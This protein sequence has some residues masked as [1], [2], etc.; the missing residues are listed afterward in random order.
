MAML[1]WTLIWGGVYSI[2][3]TPIL[4]SLFILE[5]WLEEKLTLTKRFGEAY[6]AYRKKIPAFF[7]IVLIVPLLITA[8][9]IG[10]GILAGWISLV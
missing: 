3:L 7:P 2:L 6:A 10:V 4:Y 9:T 1:G 5:A 8:L